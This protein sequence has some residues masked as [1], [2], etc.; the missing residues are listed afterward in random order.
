METLYTMGL[1]IHTVG[2]VVLMGVVMFNIAMLAFAKQIVMYAK[3][4]RIVMPIS[5]SL[6]ALVLF[7]GSIMMAAKHLEFT[8]A[9]LVMI[10]AGIVMIVLEIKRYKTLKYK[11]NIHS[12]NPLGEYKPKAFRYLGIEMAIL[13]LLSIWMMS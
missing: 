3:R 10:V 9:N 1:E 13:I 2:V 8:L 4:M 5:S 6:I 7:T 12:E 11:S